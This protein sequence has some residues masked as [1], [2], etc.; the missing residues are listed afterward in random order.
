MRVERVQAHAFGP[1]RDETLELASGMN[2]VHGP[3]EAGKSS[4]HAALYLGLCG[5]RQGKGRR[6]SDQDIE[7]RHRPWD[8]PAAWEVGLTIRLADGRRVELRHNLAEKHGSASDA[9]I[10]ERRYDGDIVTDGALDGSRWLGLDREM[11]LQTACVR[12]AQMLAVR[13]NADSLQSHLQAAVAK[14]E[15]DATAARALNALVDYR[16][17]QIGSA[18]APTKPLAQ[19]REAAAA[20]RRRHQQA[21][22]A[23][24]DYRARCRVARGLAEEAE[25]RARQLRAGRALRARQLASTAAERLR[26]ARRLS[27]EFPEGAPRAKADDTAL[28]AQVASAI[29]T[30]DRLRTP[31]PPDGETLEELSQ[32]QSAA[33]ADAVANEREAPSARPSMPAVFVAA[34]L[35]VAGGVAHFYSGRLFFLPV[36]GALCFLVL[37]LAGRQAK[38][39]GARRIESEKALL[40]ER[41]DSLRQRISHRELKDEAYALAMDQQ[42]EAARLLETAAVAAGCAAA[43]ASADHQRAALDEWQRERPTRIAEAEA[44]QRRWSELTGLLGGKPIEN[45]QAECEERDEEARKMLAECADED[46]R[47]APQEPLQDLAKKEQEAREKWIACDG[48]LVAERKKLPDVAATEDASATAQARFEHYQRQDAT[49]GRAIDFLRAAEEAVHR[50]VARVLRHTILEWL[51]TI[52]E[53]RYTDCRVNPETLE[54]QVCGPDGRWRSAELLSHGASEQIYL[55]VRLALV[56]RLTATREVCPLI[57]DDVVSACDKVRKRAILDTLLA[58][59]AQTQVVLFTHDDDVAEWARARLDGATSHRIIELPRRS[60]P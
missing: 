35:L 2:V 6:K 8:E 53:G 50:D 29:A 33:K 58:V 42:A 55:V 10:A 36:F 30:W 25:K 45:L 40:R 37:W 28:V 24:E 60:S 46:L 22:E 14:S 4:W 16:R 52:T 56:R 39:E 13:D 31:H 59:S 34:G 41:L 15:G 20:A 26:Q 7:R 21:L 43:R 48:A 32:M 54:V 47:L 9:D 5:M 44:E 57:L 17:E 11:F 51:A 49:I 23:N 38:A 12:Q 18:K 1:F 3:N 19:A 27:A